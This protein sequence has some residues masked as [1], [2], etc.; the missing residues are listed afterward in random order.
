LQDGR[1]EG[2]II[3]CLIKKKVWRMGQLKVTSRRMGG[4]GINVKGEH[5]KKTHASFYQ[6]FRKKEQVS[7]KTGR[8]KE[9]K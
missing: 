9:E 4:V 5:R 8:G 3:P 2:G 1:R 6:K 7:H